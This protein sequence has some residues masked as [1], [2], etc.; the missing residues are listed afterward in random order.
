MLIY[1]ASEAQQVG[2]P[3]ICANL[4]NAA[5]IIYSNGPRTPFDIICAT[6]SI[7]NSIIISVFTF[8][9][10][11]ALYFSFDLES[12]FVSKRIVQLIW[13]AWFFS[14]Y[15]QFLQAVNRFLAI[16]YAV[17]YIRVFTVSKTKIYMTIL[18]I[19]TSWHYCIQFFE[20][21]QF[22][23]YHANMQWYFDTTICG[24]ILSMYADLC[25][26]FLLLSISIVLDALT[27]MRVIQFIKKSNAINRHFSALDIRFFIQGK[28]SQHELHA[29]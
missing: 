12:S 17:V 18:L 1:R 10:S 6:H 29:Q 23:F 16:N 22:K 13:F 4:I 20:G 5:F 9:G 7:A 21:C 2:L 14:L 15:S 27:A 24:Y 26:T 19:Y 25:V 28:I 11:P 8:Y 3:G